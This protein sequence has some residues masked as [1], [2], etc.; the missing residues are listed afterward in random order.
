[1]QE[2]WGL[3][4][5]IKN[6]TLR[7]AEQGELNALAP[8][9]YHGRVASTPDEATHLMTGLD[10]AAAVQE[11]RGAATFLASKGCE[12]I[13]VSGFCM[14]GALSFA[15]AIHCGD[16]IH[17]AAPFYGTPKGQ[18]LSQIKIPVQAHFGVNDTHAGFSDKATGEK[19]EEAIKKSGQRVE[20]YWYETG[21][22]FMNDKRPE[23]YH[24]ES[25]K[26]ALERVLNFTKSL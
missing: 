14:G 7:W 13:L 25:A 22:A 1:M 11:V 8:D 12:K 6:L 23:A 20:F 4:E 16:L 17:G 26:L 2:W 15:A 10:F 19:A 9:L 5:Q 18:D 3:N 24:P 21:H